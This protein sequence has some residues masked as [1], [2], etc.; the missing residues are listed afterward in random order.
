MRKALPDR[1]HRELKTG[2]T[3]HHSVAACHVSAKFPQGKWIATVRRN[4]Q[5]RLVKYPVKGFATPLDALAYVKSIRPDAKGRVHAPTQGEARVSDL[6]EY[7]RVHMW[8]R[9][10][11]KRQEMKESR[12]RIHIEPYWGDMPLSAVTRR[13]V[14]EWITETEAK[15]AGQQGSGGS[16]GLAQLAQCRIDLHGMFEALGLFDPRFEDRLNPFRAKG[17]SFARLEQRQ[18]V[19]L[20]SHHFAAIVRASQRLAEEGLVTPWIGPVFLTSL[21]SG[22]RAGEVLALCR[23]QIDF[24]TGIIT[25]DRAVREKAQELDPVTMRPSGP[26]HRF[27]VNLPKGDKVR[28]VPMSDHLVPILKPLC[29]GSKPSG[30]AWD[31]LFPNDQGG[32]KEERRVQLAFA[33]MCKRLGELAKHERI[34]GRGLPSNPLMDEFAGI[35]LPDV[36]TTIVFR[37]T[38]NS[39]ASYAE[40]VGIPQATREAILG[41]G[42]RG[43]T[44]KA[45]TDVTSKGLQEARKRLSKGWKPL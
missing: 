4:E 32:L 27:A 44:N 7:S 40:E 10:S 16:S 41:H 17:L 24:R 33:T 14:Q 20:E 22:L 1:V 29:T 45:Y 13:A 26:V 25:V 39:F 9:L 3:I 8:K 21:L 19:C 18:R 34:G 42:P 15:L 2:E 30:A 23:D 36:W 38:R 12:W 28:L 11:A 37:D 31:L 35:D 43:V 6:Y 5:G